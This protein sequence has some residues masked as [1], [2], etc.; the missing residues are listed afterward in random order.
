MGIF[1]SIQSIASDL[2]AMRDMMEAETRTLATTPKSICG[3]T[4]ILEPQIARDF[5]EFS[6]KEFCPDAHRMIEQKLR[7]EGAT[8]I[9]FHRTEISSYRKEHGNCVITLQ[10]ALEYLPSPE[11]DAKRGK[12]LRGQPRQVRY[13]SELLY[14]QDA[15][16]CQEQETAVGVTCPHCGAP[17][18]VLGQKK[19]EYCGGALMVINRHVWT[20]S[21]IYE[22]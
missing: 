1:R 18:T 8:G 21:R 6:W 11:E 17:I 12:K 13:N 22:A 5:P 16:A 9:R 4:K 10:S 19:C 2:S 7:S 14:V 20:L 15:D 3:M